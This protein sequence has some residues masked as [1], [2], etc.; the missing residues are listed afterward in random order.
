M[1]A[2]VLAGG[3]GTRLRPLTNTTTKQLLPVA[4]RPILFYIMD[5]VKQANITD[6]GITISPE[7]G[8][9]VKQAVGDGSRW[10]GHVTYILQPEPTGL[11]HA[12]KVAQ[13]FLDDYPFLMI[14]GDN[15]YN[16]PIRDFV[17]QFQEDSDGLLLLKEVDTPKEFGIAELNSKGRVVHVEEKPEQTQSNLALAGAYLF[18]PAIHDA[19]NAT[20]PSLR[21]ELEI[22]DA[23][24]QLIDSGGKVNGYIINGWWLDTGNTDDLLQANSRVLDEFL[25]E[26]IHGQVDS[27]SKITGKVEIKGGSVIENAQIQGPVSIA[28][29]CFIKDSFVGPFTSVGAKTRLEESSVEC[30]IIME[31]CHLSKVGHLVDSVLGKRVKLFGQ[32][33]QAKS[34][35]LFLGD[36]AKVEL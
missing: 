17:G 22:T 16:F 18:S 30:S 32:G 1:K 5:M 34:I 33:Q 29:G 4:N 36:D 19:I 26:N 27:R 28:E 11:A 25:E 35:G 24:Q 21:G 6:I 20:V 9:Q 13:P 14:L 31:H 23:I 7:W 12:I 15:V 3:K 2:L 8:E 10:G